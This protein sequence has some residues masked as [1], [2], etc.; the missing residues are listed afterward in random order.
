MRCHFFLWMHNF[1]MRLTWGFFTDCCSLPVVASTCRFRSLSGVTVRPQ[2]ISHLSMPGISLPYCS[3][4]LSHQTERWSHSWQPEARTGT[5]RTCWRAWALKWAL[6]ACGMALATDWCW[7]RKWGFL[8]HLLWP[9]LDDVRSLWN[10]ESQLSGPWMRKTCSLASGQ[11][12]AFV[13]LAQT[14]L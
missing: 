13:A 7:Q 10:A 2:V 6:E 12:T 1:V 8:A 9:L 3:L 4:T 11:W 5:C 14:R